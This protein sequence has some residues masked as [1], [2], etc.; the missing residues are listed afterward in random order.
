MTF[1]FSSMFCVLQFPHEGKIVTINKIEYC[2]PSTMYTIMSTTVP[3]VG[4]NTPPYE[5]VSL[6]IYKIPSLTGVFPIPHTMVYLIWL[7]P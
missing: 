1:V 5:C 3:F 2:V 6:R 4:D 7:L